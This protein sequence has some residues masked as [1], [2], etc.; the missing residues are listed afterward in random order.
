MLLNSGGRSTTGLDICFVFLFYFSSGSKH[1]WYDVDI[2]NLVNFRCKIS[3]CFYCN[4]AM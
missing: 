2:I 3:F 4:V 1:Y